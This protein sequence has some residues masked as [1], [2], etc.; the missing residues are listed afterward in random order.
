M[1]SSIWADKH[2]CGTIGESVLADA[3]CTEV[4]HI[5]W[6]SAIH[7]GNCQGVV[8]SQ[9]KALGLCQ[10]QGR[11]ADQKVHLCSNTEALEQGK[12]ALTNTYD[13]P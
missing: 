4:P 13:S 8:F 7:V 9:D 1:G 2:A 6:S 3:S 11:I 12:S 5:G 10:A